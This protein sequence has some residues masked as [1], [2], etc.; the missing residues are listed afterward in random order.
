MSSYQQNVEF[1]RQRIS[2]LVGDLKTFNTTHKVSKQLVC[3][4]ALKIRKG[5]CVVDMV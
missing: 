3:V 1:F 5:M 4:H 2:E